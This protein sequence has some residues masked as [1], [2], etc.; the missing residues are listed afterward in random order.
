MSALDSGKRPKVRVTIKGYTYRSSVAS[1]GGRFLVG[2]SAEV[3][4]H[5]GVA[6]GDEVD[7]DI[8]LDTEA[9]KVAVPAD[10]RKALDGDAK[11][12]AFF[13]SLAYSH[14]SRHVLSIEAAKTPETRQRRIDKAVIMLHEGRK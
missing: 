1:M 12:G 11:A 7:V 14:Q 3:R 2:V 6:A 8:A 13:D 9:R 5:A 10:F 4:N